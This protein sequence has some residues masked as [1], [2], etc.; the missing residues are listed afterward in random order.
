MPS[1]ENASRESLFSSD[2]LEGL[3][4]ATQEAARAADAGTQ[5][6]I[7]AL[8]VCNKVHEAVTAS[9]MGDNDK[10]RLLLHE[11]I[12]Q[13]TDVRLL[14][15]AF[16]FHFRLGNYDEAERLVRL[17]L[18]AVRPESIDEARAWTN[19]GLINFF[20]GDLNI[21][22]EMMRRA[23]E[24]DTR[25]GNEQGIARDLGNLSLIPE[26]RKDFDAAEKLN[27]ES[28][29]IAERIGYTPVIA[30]RLCN[31][32]EIALARGNSVDARALLVRA[33]AEFAKLGIEKHRSHCERLIRQID[34]PESSSSNT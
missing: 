9:D 5:D 26:S 31:L 32:G 15:L 12:E 23:L 2:T 7:L 24:I 11:A 1:P 27:R 14:Y 19:Y 17:R 21:A 28:L 10:A 22:E 25:I 33:E 13:T 30:T 8:H 3:R 16:Q 4:D 18:Q 20:R 29:A 6:G 34:S